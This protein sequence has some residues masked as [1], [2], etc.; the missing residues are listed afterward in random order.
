MLAARL[1]PFLNVKVIRDEIWDRSLRDCADT[2]LPTSSFPQK[3]LQESSLKSFQKMKEA[4]KELRFAIR[5]IK[6]S[7]I[8][9]M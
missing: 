8:V 6:V 9:F 3:K 5:F 4:E 1:S 7:L 2:Q